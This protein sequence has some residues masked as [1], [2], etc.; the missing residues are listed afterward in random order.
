MRSEI[1]SNV[2]SVYFAFAVMFCARG[3]DGTN[4]NSSSKARLSAKERFQQLMFT[5][6]AYRQEALRLVIEEANRVASELHLSEQLPIVQTNLVATYFP[7]PRMAHGMQAIGNITTS[8]YTYYVSVGNKFSYLVRTHLEQEYQQL[9]TQYLWPMSRMDTNLAYQVATQILSAASMNVMALNRDC[10]VHIDAF[11]PE[12]KNGAHFVPIYWVYWTK[13][14][15]VGS[16]ASLE[17]LLPTKTIRQLHVNKSDYI[18][19]KPLEI[20]NVDFLLSQTN[21]PTSADFP[22][23]Q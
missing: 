16:V 8:N 23:K 9:K 15:E 19:R 3:Q 1:V 6:D 7:P 22:V 18:L 21:A 10:K 11:I 20:T 2:I 17:L 14:G 12:G 5:T 13:D 4:D